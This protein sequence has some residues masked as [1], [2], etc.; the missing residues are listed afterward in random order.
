MKMLSTVLRELVH[1]TA[2]GAPITDASQPLGTA[3]EMMIVAMELT[4]HQ[5]IA[6]LREE[7]ASGISSH[8]TMAIAFPGFT[9]AMGTM[10]AWTTAMKTT[11]I[12]A[13]S[14]LLDNFRSVN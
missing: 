5:S 13:V 11:G 8:A 6:S 14:I 4:N 7:H 1:K 3:M 9:S 12:S 10:I 2:S